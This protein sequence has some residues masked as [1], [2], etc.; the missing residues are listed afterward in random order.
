ME[1][2]KRDVFKYSSKFQDRI[3]RLLFQDESFALG[4][5]SIIKPDLFGSKIQKWLVKKII[6][7]V[8]TYG[9]TADMDV[10]QNAAERAL[11]SGYFKKDE[12]I[13][14]NSAIKKLTLAIPNS[15]Y[16]R[17]EVFDFCRS[18]RFRESVVKAVEAYEANEQD[19][20]DQFLTSYLDIKDDHGNL[21]HYYVRDAKIRINARKRYVPNGIPTGTDL[22]DYLKGGGLPP[23]RLGCIVAPPGRGKTL[24]LINFAKG[25]ILHGHKVLYLTMEL[26]EEDIAERLDANMAGVYLG[27]L[28]SYVHKTKRAVN[29]LK[30]KFGDPLIIK[31][32]PPQTLTVAGI[33]GYL[34]RLERTGFKPDLLIIDFADYILPTKHY[35]DSYSELGLIYQELRGLAIS[36][37]LAVW[38]AS[39]GNRGSAEAKVV[40]MTSLADSFKKAGIVDV[41]IGFSQVSKER[42]RKQARLFIAK[43]RL[44]PS[45]V[46]VS[47][48]VDPAR[49]Q[50]LTAPKE[51]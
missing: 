47:I 43:N 15:S 10:I 2:S 7:H 32:F 19:K 18:L 46:E 40:D 31:F 34:R 22:D 35:E 44:G 5:T 12:A 20:A 26:L 37:R 38:T 1:P 3:I 14:L 50:I 24:A 39:Q 25:A 49:Q 23:K 45:D 9:T 21:G 28:Q 17:K 8:N 30:T 6:D 4:I 36:E 27:A 16:V 42:I 29:G 51:T 41:L 48:K 13:V 33:K 11:S